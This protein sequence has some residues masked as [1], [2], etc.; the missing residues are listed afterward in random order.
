MTNIEDIQILDDIDLE[1][2]V[3]GTKKKVAKKKAKKKVAKKKVAKKK[4]SS[5]GRAESNGG[6]FVLVS[7]NALDNAQG[8]TPAPL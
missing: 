7:Q 8:L 5:K 6:A 3:G 1:G 4:A 2:V